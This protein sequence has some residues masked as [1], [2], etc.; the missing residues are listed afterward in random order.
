MN[1]VSNCNSSRQKLADFTF[2]AHTYGFDDLLSPSWFMRPNNIYL[3]PLDYVT[4]F[5]FHFC[6]LFFCLF[7]SG[8]KRISYSLVSDVPIDLKL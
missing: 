7:S 2:L 6:F 8:M 3:D 1:T 4:V 5:S